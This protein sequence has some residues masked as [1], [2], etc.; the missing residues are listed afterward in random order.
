MRHI[1]IGMGEVGKAIYDV[2]REHYETQ[3]LDMKEPDYERRLEYATRSPEYE[4][5]HVC[6]PYF[7]GFENSVDAYQGI[8]KPKYTVI[9]STV[10]VGTSRKC[11]ATHSP[12]EGI[13]PFLKESV[14]TFE[15]YLGGEQANEIADIFRKANLRVFTTGKQETTELLKIMST[16]YFGL[17]VE[18]TKE[19]KRKCDEMG[20]PFEMWKLWNDN[21]NQ[22]YV[23]LGHP[24]YARPN[25]VPIM[26]KIGGHCVIPNLEFLASDFTDLI[27]RR[28][29]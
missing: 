2:F 26:G 18:F 22:S 13:H 24:E 23:K 21:Y 5:M 7:D 9:H 1:V 28:N 8:L 29:G 3:S 20:L 15:K 16:T 11:K 19:V 14:L 4:M 10:P 17:C 6:F 27:R 25:L 12:I